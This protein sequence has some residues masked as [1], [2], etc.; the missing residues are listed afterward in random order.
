MEIKAKDAWSLLLV[1]FLGQ[2][3]AFSMA[4]AS[5]ASSLVANLGTSL[6]LA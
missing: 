3:V 2:L 5:F 6:S 4:A 1:L